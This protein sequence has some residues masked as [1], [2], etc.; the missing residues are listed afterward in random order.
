[1]K[2]INVNVQIKRIKAL[3]QEGDRQEIRT[4]TGLSESMIRKILVGDAIYPSTIPVIEAALEV[5][6]NRNV[7]VKETEKRLKKLVK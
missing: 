2:A 4:K 3:L 6:E 1:M 7:K 5:I